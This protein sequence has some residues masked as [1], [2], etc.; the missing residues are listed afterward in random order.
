MVLWFLAVAIDCLERLV[1]EMTYY[2]SC[3]TLNSAHSCT[4]VC[5]WWNVSCD[6]VP[7]CAILWTS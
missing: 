1:H 7:C 2:V 4:L 6:K 3:G 5:C